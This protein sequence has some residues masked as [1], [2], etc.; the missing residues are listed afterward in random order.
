MKIVTFNH[1]IELNNILK[2]QGFEYK[3]HLRDACSGQSMWIESL[4]PYY[5]PQGNKG[6][7][8]LINE[9]FKTKQM[10]LEYSDNL[11]SFWVVN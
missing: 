5:S 4:N 9:Y 6:L 7:Y 11:A 8:M 10:D 1:I 3:V 2:S